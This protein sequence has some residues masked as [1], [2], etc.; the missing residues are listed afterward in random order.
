MLQHTTDPTGDCTPV[1]PDKQ[2]PE[3]GK[4]LESPTAW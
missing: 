3:T 4:D 1:A 2:R